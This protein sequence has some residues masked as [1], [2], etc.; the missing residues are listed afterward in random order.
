MAVSYLI[1]PA[2]L[3]CGKRT[4]TAD[5][6]KYQLLGVGLIVLVYVFTLFLEWKEK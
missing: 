2:L 6:W 5:D 4:P 1:A 3:A